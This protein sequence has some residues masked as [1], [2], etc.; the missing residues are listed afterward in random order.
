HEQLEC[1][2]AAT[3]RLIQLIDAMAEEARVAKA[4]EQALKLPAR[5]LPESRHGFPHIPEGFDLATLYPGHLAFEERDNNMLKLELA[6]AV[7][8]LD[9]LPSELASKE[10]YIKQLHSLLAAAKER[11]EALLTRVNEIH[12]RT[13]KMR[14]HYGIE[15]DRPA[16]KNQQPE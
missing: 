1:S 6:A 3:P 15:D 14:K 12:Q 13:I 16:E 7:K 9:S 2:T 5:I 10:N 4:D 8:R 11:E